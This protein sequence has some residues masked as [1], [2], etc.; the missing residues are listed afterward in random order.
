VSGGGTASRAGVIDGAPVVDGD[1]RSIRVLRVIA[2]LNVGGP[3]IQALT[4]T[5]LLEPFGYQ[6]TL[7]R[8][9]EGPREGSMDHLARELGIHP[10]LMTSL[11]RSLGV[12]DLVAMLQLTRLVRSTRPHLIHTHAAKAGALGRLACIVAGDAAPPVRVHT[13]HGHVL[14]E[15]FSPLASATF[16][17]V[18]RA[19]A[20]ATSK[21]VAVSEEVKRDLLRLGVGRPEQIRVVPVGF[22][23]R[24]FRLNQDE[25]RMQRSRVRRE[26]QITDD[27]RVVTLVARLV[28]I[29]RVDRFLRIAANL[30]REFGVFFVVVGD[31]ELRRGLQQSDPARA[32]GHRLRW[33]GIRR[34][35]PA[36]M[37]ASDLVVLTS[38]N[39]GTPVSLIEAHAAGRAVVS[40]DVGGVRSVV[41]DQLSGYVVPKEAENLFAN[42]VLTLLRDPARAVKFGQQGRKHV[43]EH[44]LLDRLVRDIDLLYRELLSAR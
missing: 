42:R 25:E 38:D 2:R 15:Y 1:R 4:L 43:M 44:F 36:M 29:K 27:A 7:V 13:F 5:K 8:G 39:E 41:L 18:E 33:T 23:L 19:L 9:L 11:R 21:L 32:L 40:T 22:D 12:N 34:D 3:S 28:P 24:A 31:G 6:T 30:H 10:R 37:A 20:R 16:V 26:L 17:R 35:M 14:S